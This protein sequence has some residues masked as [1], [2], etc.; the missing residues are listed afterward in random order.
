MS[1]IYF[2]DLAESCMTQGVALKHAFQID[3]SACSITNC[4]RNVFIL[5]GIILQTATLQG[6]LERFQSSQ[7]VA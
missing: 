5:V 3:I 4:A 6:F 1:V 7:N 2:H